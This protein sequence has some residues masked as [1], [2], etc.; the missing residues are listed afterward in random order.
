[1]AGHELHSE[2]GHSIEPLESFL[3]RQV[4]AGHELHSETG[5]SIGPLG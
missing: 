1:M 3:M 5:H 4:M 2:T